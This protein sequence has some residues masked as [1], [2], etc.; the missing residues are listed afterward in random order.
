MDTLRLIGLDTLVSTSAD[1][2]PNEDTSAQ[3]AK[4]P[5]LEADGTCSFDFAL[6]FH[7]PVRWRARQDW[8]SEEQCADGGRVTKHDSGTYAGT[9]LGGWPHRGSSHCAV[10]K[11]PACRECGSD[12]TNLVFHISE[13]DV[14]PYDWGDSAPHIV[15][16]CPAHYA[17]MA[18]Q[19]LC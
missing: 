9:K 17:E 1:I 7:R 3:L 14:L 19:F 5:R 13:D 10:V 11:Y 8:P 16:Q 15:L 18:F 6:P 4:C 12:M 2:G